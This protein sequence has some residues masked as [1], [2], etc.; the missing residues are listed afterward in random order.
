MATVQVGLKDISTS[1]LIHK[2][3]QLIYCLKDNIHFP[4][5]Q[6]SVAFLK[7]KLAEVQKWNLSRMDRSSMSVMY[8]KQ[9]EAGLKIAI[10]NLASYV[11]IHAQGD[12][13]KIIG[14]GFAVRRKPGRSKDVRTPQGLSSQSGHLSGEIKLTWNRDRP[15]ILFLVEMAEFTTDSDWC[16]KGYTKKSK[17]TVGGLIPGHKYQ[18]RLKAIGADKESAYS[19]PTA[20]MAI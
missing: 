17:Y 5:P 9:A 20:R 4:D 2:T 16:L 3:N 15:G 8:R 6:P 19:Q 13:T 14:S 11:D 10:K 12:P 18:F 1:D 7:E